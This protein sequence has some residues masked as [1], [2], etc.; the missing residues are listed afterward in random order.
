[1]G[2]L[3]DIGE[4]LKNLG[5]DVK[6]GLNDGIGALE[7]G[8]DE[9][10]RLAGKGIDWGTNKVGEGL[11]H[12]GLHGA[13]DAV[14][15]WGDEVASDLGATPGEQ[16]LGQ[17]EDANELVHGNSGRISESAKHLKDF[18]AAFDKVGQGMRSL[19]SA[20]WR[21]EGGDAFRKKFEMHPSKWLHAS[22]ACETA[23]DALVAYADT[24]KWAQGQAKEAIALYKKGKQASEQ[25]V[26]TYNER[27]DAYN[28]KIK[29]DQDPGPV[30]EPF[31]DPGRADIEGA[32]EK[33]AEARRQRNTAAATARSKIRSALAHAPA[34]PPPLDRLGDNLVDGFHAVNTELTHVAGGALKGASGIL[35]FA[36]G[37]NPLD[38]YNL[39]HPAE[40]AQNVN[41]TLSGLVSTAA[42]PERII[43]AAVDGFKKD[44]SEFVGR[45]LPELVGTKGAGFVRSGTRLGLK[46]ADDIPGTTPSKWDDLARST[47]TVKEK[48]IH[49]ESVDP[50]RAQEFLDS[51][52]PWLRDVNNTGQPGYTM[53]CSHN[54]VAV[55]RRLDG[56]D[57]SAA[58]KQGGDHIPP[59]QLGMKDRPKGQYDFV[60]SYDEIIRDLQ[61]RGDGSRSAV[62][63]SRP[64]NTAHIF[65]A[66][67]TPHGVVFL[68]GQSGTLG[69]LERNVSSIGHIPYRNGA[70]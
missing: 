31:K 51:E 13:A 23:G 11:D 65:N 17:T 40:Y 37:L 42:Q 32:R 47:E 56:I 67:N 34:E 61:A 12:V 54:T 4:G 24:V 43:Q 45:L 35:N 28:A 36:R 41:M 21:G 33:L 7:D 59:E 50:K 38:P 60:N 22:D 58:P 46:Y 57:V 19:D 49:Y 44:P 27:I 14:Q 39:T 70:P 52:Y 29:A 8:L 30:P 64:N 1:M 20:H 53:N 9:G 63:I 15:D 25:A 68:D 6:D 66:V 10:K 2:V 18:Q 55:D 48:A 69:M 16:Q 5:G 62:Y 26:R 3:G